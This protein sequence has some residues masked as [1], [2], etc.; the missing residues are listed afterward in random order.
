MAID[1]GIDQPVGKR[2]AQQEMVDAQSCIAAIGVPKVIPEGVDRLVRMDLAERVGPALAGQSE[3]GLSN[4]G[5]NNASSSQR[6]G[7]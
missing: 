5:A 1:L 6:S 3:E 7:L 4:L 2:R